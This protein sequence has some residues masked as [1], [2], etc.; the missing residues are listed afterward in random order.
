V[1]P[2]EGR[3]ARNENI[4]V[5]AEPLQAAVPKVSMNVIV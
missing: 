4:R 1:Q 5:I 3:I 2:A